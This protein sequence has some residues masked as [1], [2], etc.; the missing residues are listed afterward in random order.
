MGML[1]MEPSQWRGKTLHVEIAD[2]SQGVV[3]RC[4][5]RNTYLPGM[6]AEIASGVV[7][8]NEGASSRLLSSLLLP[9]STSL[10]FCP[11][12]VTYHQSSG[13]RYHGFVHAGQL[14]TGMSPR[15]R[16]KLERLATLRRSVE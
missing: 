9:P 8:G 3:H 15:L 2:E 16:A 10:H 4:P 6:I 1:V 7:T 14:S 13:L 5:Q 12:M 11:L